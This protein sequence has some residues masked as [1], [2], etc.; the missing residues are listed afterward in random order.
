VL[1]G[2]VLVE[3]VGL[4]ACHALLAVRV[5]IARRRAARQRQDDL[6]RFRS[7]L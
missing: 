2:G 6:E 3:R 4:G 7:L 5:L 1:T